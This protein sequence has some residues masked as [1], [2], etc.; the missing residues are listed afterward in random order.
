MGVSKYTCWTF[1]NKM[2]IGDSKQLMISSGLKHFFISCYFSWYR[3]TT[4]PRVT[5]TV[6]KGSALKYV[7]VF[8]RYW[9]ILESPCYRVVLAYKS[10]HQCRRVPIPP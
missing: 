5:N 2:A 6:T 1:F 3:F 4:G 8:V 7:C 9:Y 10:Y